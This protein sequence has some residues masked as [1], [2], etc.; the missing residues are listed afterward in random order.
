MMKSSRLPD[1]EDE[2]RRV[3]FDVIYHEILG[4]CMKSDT[5]FFE[6]FTKAA[7]VGL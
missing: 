2:I 3:I 6:N 4:F 5:I 1:K 7:Q